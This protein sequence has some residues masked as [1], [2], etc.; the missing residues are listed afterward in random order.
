LIN[1][2]VSTTI[3]T[4]E[5]HRRGFYRDHG[6]YLYRGH[7]LYHC[8]HGYLDHDLDDHLYYRCETHDRYHPQI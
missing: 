1:D 7:G 8:D 4:N 5:N 6:Y 2:S 3:S